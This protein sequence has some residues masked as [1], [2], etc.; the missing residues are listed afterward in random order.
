MQV[1]VA[2]RRRPWTGDEEVVDQCGRDVTDRADAVP[3]EE[4]I[5]QA[6]GALLGTVVAPERALVRQKGLHPVGEDAPK[7]DPEA[8]HT[9]SSSPSPQAT[10][11]RVSMATLL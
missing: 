2:A 1:V 10:S 3:R 4:A 9:T 8:A 6:Q 7:S 11:R 5:E